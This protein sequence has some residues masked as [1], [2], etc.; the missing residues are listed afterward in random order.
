MNELRLTKGAS[1]FVFFFVW[2]L[3]GSFF[4]HAGDIYTPDDGF[5]RRRTVS[6]D[7]L[8]PGVYMFNIFVE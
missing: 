6:E 5:G 8:G 2:P 7:Q 3:G 4:W 1:S